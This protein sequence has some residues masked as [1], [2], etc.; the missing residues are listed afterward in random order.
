MIETN[1]TLCNRI[2]AKDPKALEQLYVENEHALYRF[3]YRTIKNKAQTEDIIHF[4]FKRLWKETPH[5]P[6]QTYRQWLYSTARQHV[7]V[8]LKEKQIHTVANN[9]R[10]LS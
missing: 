3:I 9:E 7:I 1:Q 4:L 2:R 8:H 5:L 10:L 6:N